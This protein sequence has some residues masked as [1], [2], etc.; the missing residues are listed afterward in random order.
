MRVSQP[1]PTKVAERADNAPARSARHREHPAQPF[2]TLHSDP[3]H[4]T[5]AHNERQ[6]QL[7]D[8]QAPAPCTHPTPS[9]NSPQPPTHAHKADAHRA[10]GSPG[11][12]ESNHP[13]SY[14]PPSHRP[15]RTA[16]AQSPTSD[17]D[18]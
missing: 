10:S 1:G 5:A 11:S 6:P 13:T 18:R 17:W 2:A 3:A 16:P 12:G 8:T 14:G 9:R 7:R 4:S 15:F